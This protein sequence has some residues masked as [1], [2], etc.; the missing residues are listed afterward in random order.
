MQYLY[1]EKLDTNRIVVAVWHKLDKYESMN[2]DFSL[3][4]LWFPV[5]CGLS[6]GAAGTTCL[7]IPGSICRRKWRDCLHQWNYVSNVT[8]LHSH[9]GRIVQIHCECIFQHNNKIHFVFRKSFNIYS[10]WFMQAL[11]LPL[12]V[13][14]KT[15]HWKII[16]PVQ[17]QKKCSKTL[18]SYYTDAALC[19]TQCRV[20]WHY[21][22]GQIRLSRPLYST[23]EHSAAL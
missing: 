16:H 13:G 11:I 5:S 20:M 8:L 9:N 6:V 2:K 21:G 7:P 10:S 4:L 17:G 23:F 22:R 3:F 1:N 18:F 19:L 12:F 15:N 14:Y